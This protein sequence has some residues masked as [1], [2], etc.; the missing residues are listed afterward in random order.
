V[1]PVPE[2][3]V[4]GH[5]SQSFSQNKHKQDQGDAPESFQAARAKKRDVPASFCCGEDWDHVEENGLGTMSAEQNLVH[6]PAM[7]VLN[8]TLVIS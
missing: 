4:P 1:P 8:L 5:F 3:K 6:I 2:E 7:R